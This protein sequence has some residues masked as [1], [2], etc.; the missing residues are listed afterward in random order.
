[1]D[2]EFQIDNAYSPS[3]K[4][5]PTHTRRGST[6]HREQERRPSVV[7]DAKSQ[8]RRILNKRPRSS[9]Y[10]TGTTPYNKKGLDF[11]LGALRFGGAGAGGNG[12]EKEDGVSTSTHTHG[13]KKRRKSQIGIDVRLRSAD[14][15]TQEEYLYGSPSSGAHAGGGGKAPFMRNENATGSGS[16][17]AVGGTPRKEDDLL[18]STSPP[19]GGG[20]PGGRLRTD[21]EE[22]YWN[23]G[24]HSIAHTVRG[25]FEDAEEE[26]RQRSLMQQLQQQQLGAAVE[27]LAMES[28]TA[29]SHSGHER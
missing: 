28:S 4:H 15:H 13:K 14:D 24:D 26:E 17:F 6:V 3:T 16:A 29:R 23:Y 8:I 10:P 7:E 18:L 5:T 12:G 1:M 21:S 9:S 27:R 19:T 25:S 20:G 22:R 11:G 2:T